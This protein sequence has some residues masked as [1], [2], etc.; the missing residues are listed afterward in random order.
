MSVKVDQIASG[1]DVS[2]VGG[3]RDVDGVKDITRG[4]LLR[5]VCAMAN[6]GELMNSI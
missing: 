4:M 6:S 1:I 2:C 5:S 3:V